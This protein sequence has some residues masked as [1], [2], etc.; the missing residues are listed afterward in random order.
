MGCRRIKKMMS[1]YIDDEL[2]SSAKEAFLLH[3]GKCEK[4]SKEF[5]ETQA[6]HLLF[7]NAKRTPAPYGFT[8]RVMA[9][10]EPK[11]LPGKS[12]WD[13]FILRPL[14]PRMAGVVLAL[15][16][17]ILGIIAGSHLVNNR[18]INQEQTSLKQAFALDVFQATPPD[19]IGGV[20]AD[21]MEAKNEG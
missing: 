16:V 8:S 5:E 2:T 6:V 18:A 10:L 19:S 20:Y 15:A 17:M 9:K 12:I 3:I 11:A 13:T 7:T 4:C 14:I 21:I 1:G